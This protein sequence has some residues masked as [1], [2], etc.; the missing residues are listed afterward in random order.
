M[1]TGNCVFDALDECDEDER[2]RLLDKIS[3]NMSTNLD[4]SRADRNQM[5]WRLLFTSRP[6]I[7]SR[8]S[9]IRGYRVLDFNDSEG[10]TKNESDIEKSIVDG[11]R[12][13]PNYPTGLQ[14]SLK[15]GLIAKAD[16][17]FRW[18]SCML[19]AFDN[20]TIRDE[21]RLWD[22]PLPKMDT[23]F[24]SLVNGVE[25]EHVCFIEWVELAYRPLSV[26]ELSLAAHINPDE[27][28]KVRRMYGN[29][30]TV[31]LDITLLKGA[32]K[33]RKGQAA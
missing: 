28:P 31:Q 25:A 30:N 7:K 32:V 1:V 5:R 23:M 33:L 12:R 21:E 9:C 4:A 15:E 19:E 16:G 8:L 14:E 22:L 13:L 2:K 17:N 27:T 18:R 20:T 29:E 6:G 11:I 24:T 26:T 3:E 10:T